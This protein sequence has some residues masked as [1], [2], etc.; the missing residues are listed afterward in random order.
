MTALKL[1]ASEYVYNCLKEEIIFLELLPG[2]TINEVETSNRFNVSRTPVRDA[3]NRLQSEGLVEVRPKFGTFVTLIDI[4]EISDIMYMREKLELAVIK[5]IK[6]VS[7]SQEVKMDVLLLQ[8]RR[9]LDSD[10]D[11]FQMAQKFL[12]ADNEFHAAIFN[13]DNKKSIWKKI[14]AD[15]PHYNRLRLL[16]NRENKDELDKIYE[17]HTKIVKA[18]ISK[19][20]ELLDEYYN[21]HIY[22][23]I[24]NLAEIVNK[25]REYFK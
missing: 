13:L 11:E 20:Y 1:S 10:L 24:Q 17:D 18:I 21:K 16:A 3:F 2:Q 23:G 15:N 19:D 8:Q 12:E 5:D 14:A 25:Y 4:D 7:K 6:H 22:E 9:I